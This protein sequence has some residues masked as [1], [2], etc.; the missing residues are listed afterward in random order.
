MPSPSKRVRIHN[1]ELNGDADAIE[2]DM[3]QRGM[4]IA[5]SGRGWAVVCWQKGDGSGDDEEE[6]C[7]MFAIVP[8]GRAFLSYLPDSGHA[9]LAFV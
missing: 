6:L 4:G 2:L 9:I 1:A 5:L 7:R 3:L 8:D